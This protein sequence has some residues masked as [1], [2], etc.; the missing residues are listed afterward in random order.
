MN[1]QSRYSVGVDYN[2]S[3]EATERH[4]DNAL[5]EQLQKDVDDFLKNKKN[6]IQQIDY[7]GNVL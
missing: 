4:H 2:G 6:K 3:K 1:K 5:R 7:V